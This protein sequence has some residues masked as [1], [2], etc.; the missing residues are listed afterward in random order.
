MN[1]DIT[2]QNS[3]DHFRDGNPLVWNEVHWFE[4]SKR[5]TLQ[6]FLVL[7]PFFDRAFPFVLHWDLEKYYD[8]RSAFYNVEL[9]DLLCVVT[10]TKLKRF[11]SVF[12]LIQFNSISLQISQS[13]VLTFVFQLRSCYF[14]KT[15]LSGK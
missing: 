1:H 8:A 10:S 5:A 11:R 12:M 4:L 13:N 7:N 6:T 9:Y 3:F 14:E 2:E 15:V